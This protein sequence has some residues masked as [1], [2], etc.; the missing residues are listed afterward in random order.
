MN[1]ARLCGPPSFQ[2][3]SIQL[4]ANTSTDYPVVSWILLRC[5]R[6]VTAASFVQKR[7]SQVEFARVAQFL[8]FQSSTLPRYAAGYFKE[9]DAVHVKRERPTLHET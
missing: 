4:S 5:C 7:I 9:L 6:S 1:D 8:L 2:G 3:L